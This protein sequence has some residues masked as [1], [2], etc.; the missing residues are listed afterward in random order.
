MRI[1]KAAGFC[2]LLALVATLAVENGGD[3]TLHY[4]FGLETRPIP[5]SLL[6]LF[7]VF[8]GI[9]IASVFSI[10]FFSRLKRTIRMRDHAVEGLSRELEV[11]KESAGENRKTSGL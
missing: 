3:V 2:L 11:L 9:L 4:Y 6:I 10:G 1:V 7:S 8:V 5:L